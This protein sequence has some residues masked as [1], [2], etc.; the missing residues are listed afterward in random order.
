MNILLLNITL[1]WVF[2]LYKEY[3]L[4]IKQFIDTNY[5]DKNINIEI[6]YIE[7]LDNENDLQIDKI[8]EDYKIIK[9]D[10]I[11]YTGNIEIL[12][13]LI[14][15][16]KND[17]KNI[18][19]INIEQMSHS[20]YYKMIRKIINLKNII[21]YSEENI[22]YYKNVYNNFFLLPPYFN[23]NKNI[24]QNIKSIDLLSIINNSY[25]ENKISKIK[26]S[27]KQQIR[28]LKNCFGDVRDD[29]YSKTK[30]YINIHCSNEHNTMEMIR[31]VNLIMNKV[32][33]LTQ[34]SIC[35]NLIFLKKYLFICNDADEFTIEIQNI[36][37][38]Y[39]LYYN[40]IYG[41]FNKDDYHQY[42][43]GCY[44]PLINHLFE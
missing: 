39:D 3:I 6:L 38:N 23:F 9:Y 2:K 10:K 26:V 40:K 19:F 14:K 33:I 30:I 25:R 1:N 8:I 18:Y 43:I 5:P 41:D 4:S 24:K 22:P 13:L 36:L 32:I 16:L 35:T 21:D 7:M 31:L 12:N 27:K 11:F 29:Y 37:N 42:L 15:E 17:S 20:S 34:P 28:L 44:T